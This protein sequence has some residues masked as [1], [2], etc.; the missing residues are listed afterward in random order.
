MNVSVITPSY[1]QSIFIERTIKS[2]LEQNIPHLEYV[3]YDA[4]SVDG[5]IDILRQYSG[6]IRW[7]SEN[8]NGQ[9]HAVNKGIQTTTGDIIGWLNSDDIY[10]P[11]AIK[12]VC[13]YFAANP[14]VDVIYGHAN[15]IDEYDNIIE[16][17][18]TEEWNLQ[19]LYYTC[20]LS[21]PAVFFRRSVVE[22]Y[23]L[24]DEQLHYAMDYEYWLRLGM[25]G[26]KFMYI[27]ELLAGSRLYAN[28][29]TLGARVKVHSEINMM[30]KKLLGKVP[31]RWLINYAHAILE[32]KNIKREN[33]LKYFPNLLCITLYS[34]FK[35]NKNISLSLL[36]LI[37][38]RIKVRLIKQFSQVRN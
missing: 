34:S 27:P 15:H 21:Q 8:D 24:L 19:R 29:K 36:G 4:N 30:L 7:I 3:I 16:S 28:T 14:S 22:K 11:G 18:P 1:N 9:S 5:T 32:S 17:Y 33:R 6:L 13:D 12:V 10:Y 20:F 2:V 38:E 35:W 25:R 31:S 23:G 37:Y 26:A